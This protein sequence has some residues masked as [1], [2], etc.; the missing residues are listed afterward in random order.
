[1]ITTTLFRPSADFIKAAKAANP[2]MQF[3][4]TSF[5][6][7]NVLMRALG[8]DGVGVAVAQV[9]PPVANRSIAVVAEYQ[10]AF[11]KFS[12]K[13]QFGATTLEAY[14]AAKVLVEALRRAGARPTRDSLLGALDGMRAYDTGGYVVSFTADNH[15][16]S[17]FTEL[18]VIDRHQRFSY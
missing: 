2:G 4:S 15:N 11:E 1:M 8:K 10:A 9:V 16:G 18:T 6:G 17:A 14:I 7:P 13:P 3:V 5:A 12:G